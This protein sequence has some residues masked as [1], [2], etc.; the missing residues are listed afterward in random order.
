MT[1]IQKTASEGI[2]ALSNNR[3]VYDKMI[4]GKKLPSKCILCDE[5]ELNECGH[6]IP[7]LVMRWLKRASSKKNFYLN[8]TTEITSDTLALKI[9]CDKCEDIFSTCEKNFT[10]KY[11]KKYYRESS[12]PKIEEDIYFFALSIAWRIMAS[13]RFMRN[14]EGGEPF[15]GLLEDELKSYLLQPSGKAEIDL[16]VF[17]AD[18][19]ADNLSHDSYNNNLLQFSI[20]Q[21]IFLQYLYYC[22]GCRD[23][24]ATLA[25]VPLVHFK[26]GAYYF[27]VAS[28]GYLQKL[29]FPKKMENIVG[30]K[31][32][33]LKYSASLMGFFNHISNNNFDEIDKSI[34]PLDE[35]YDVI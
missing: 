12:S 26:L 9:L 16:Y 31:I 22:I 11:F 34:I 5:G 14:N 19:V 3:R 35:R 1:S 7:K 28:Q 21:G 4:D 25:P 23:F 8:N 30:S 13:T 32:Y 15:R 10:D 29:K 24:N 17:H 2:A 6:I 33:I 27:I 18:E 20:R